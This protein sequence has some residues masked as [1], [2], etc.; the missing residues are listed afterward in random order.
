MFKTCNKN[1]ALC[2][3]STSLFVASPRWDCWHRQLF[4]YPKKGFFLCFWSLSAHF[5]RCIL[6]NFVP[7]YC[8]THSWHLREINASRF[9][10]SSRFLWWRLLHTCCKCH[11]AVHSLLRFQVCDDVR[12]SGIFSWYWTGFTCR[13][14]T[15]PCMCWSVCGWEGG[16][17]Q[18]C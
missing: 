6:W 4:I 12:E 11:C 13:P 2:S 15:F 9:L 5:E 17:I 1:T 18:V 16:F 10:G 14:L 7:F 3:C 8:N